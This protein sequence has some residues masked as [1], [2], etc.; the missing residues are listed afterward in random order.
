MNFQPRILIHIFSAKESSPDL[1]LI[2]LGL[3]KTQNWNF[4]L[5]CRNFLVSSGF[6]WL[7]SPGCSAG[8]LG[9]PNVTWLRAC[10]AHAGFGY[11]WQPRCPPLAGLAN[12]MG[13]VIRIHLPGA[14]EGLENL[15]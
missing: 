5:G 4:S 14:P 6:C 9:L 11:I 10:G 13:A 3:S 8:L 1:W 15:W 7:S 2:N 12:N